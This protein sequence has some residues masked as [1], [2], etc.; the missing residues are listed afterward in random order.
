MTD[1]PYVITFHSPKGI[2]IAARAAIGA[3]QAV[4]RSAYLKPIYCR[5]FGECKMKVELFRQYKH[6]KMFIRK[7]M[8]ERLRV[9]I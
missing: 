1:R 7:T 5:A 6:E 3:Q 9:L 2:L 4:H 8:G